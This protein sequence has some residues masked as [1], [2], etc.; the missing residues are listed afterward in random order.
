[1]LTIIVSIHL[2]NDLHAFK[3]NS[4]DILFHF[5]SIAVLIEPIFWWEVAFVSFSKTLSE[6]FEIELF[7]AFKLWTV[8]NRIVYMHKHR[9]IS[10]STQFNCQKHFYFKLFS[11]VKQFCFK[12][13]SLAWVHILIVKNISVFGNQNVYSFLFQAIQFSQTV[14]IKT[15]QYSIKYSLCLHTVKCQNISISNNTV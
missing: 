11:L 12:Q 3:I 8:W 13:F 5:S 1:M 2:W 15:T 14:L 9:L 6:M 10:M 4:I 7:M